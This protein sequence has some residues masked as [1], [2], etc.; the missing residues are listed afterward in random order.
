MFTTSAIVEISEERCIGCKRCVSVCPSNA[1]SIDGRV[2]VV[3]DDLIAT[4][5]RITGQLLRRY[6]K[7]IELFR[8]VDAGFTVA[9][10][11]RWLP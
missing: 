3:D 7:L 4:D 6:G 11:T 2:A 1:L 10:D 8:T 9:D 5:R